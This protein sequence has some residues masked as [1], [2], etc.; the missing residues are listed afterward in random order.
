MAI[1]NRKKNVTTNVI[2]IT[3]SIDKAEILIGLCEGE[4][5]GLENGAKSLYINDTPLQ[6]SAGGDN[7]NDFNVQIYTGSYNDGDVNFMLT[8]STDPTHVGQMLAYNTPVVRSGEKTSI[9]YIS[10][11]LVIQQLMRV[12]DDGTE[13][14]SVNVKIEY[15]AT[16]EGNTWHSLTQDGKPFILSGKVT[17]S[18]ALQFKIKVPKINEPYVLKVT[19]MSEDGDNERNFNSVQFESFQEIYTDKKSFPNTALAHIYMQYSDQLSSVPT[20]SGIYKLLKIRVPSNYDPINHTYNGNWDG[21]FKIA[22][23]DNPAW[24]LYDFVM[25]DRY[26]IN[27]YSSVIIDKWDCYEAGQWCDQMVSDGKGGQEPRYTCNL[28][29]TEATNG[30]EFVSYLAGLFNAFLV[31]PSTGYLRLFID[32]DA[33]AV[34]LFTPENVTEDGFSYSFTSPETRYNDIKVS[35]TNPALNWEADT[36]RI[37]NEEDI[38]K[39]GRVTFDFV[40]VGCIREGEAMRRAYLKLISSLTEKM[41]V[42]FTTNRQAQYLS[43][44]DIILVA[45]PVLGYSLPGRIKSISAD[46]KTVYLR[47]SIYL[48]AGISYKISFNLP[49]GLWETDISPLTLTGSTKTFIVEEEL[50]DNLP[51][52][53]AFTIY[54]SENSGTPKPFRI[55]SITENDGNPDNYTITAIEINRNKWDAADNF[56]FAEMVDYSGLKSMT[57]IPQLLGASFYTGYDRVNLQNEVIITPEFD[58]S[59]PY[60]SGRIIVYSREIGTYAWTQREVVNK[61]TIKGHP[62]GDFE[63]IILPVSTTGIIP[64]FDTAPHFRYTVP[65]VNLYPSNINNLQAERSVNGVTLSWDPVS[66]VDLAGYEIREG[67]DWD[68]STLV[69]TNLAATS[70]YISITDGVTR[71]YMVA[72]KNYL[73]KYSPYPAFIS[74]NV[75]PPEDVPNFYATVSNDRIRFDWTQVEGTDIEYEIRQGANWGTALKVA[76][77]KGNNTTVLLPSIPE[78]T[79][80]I[81][82]KSLA[83][84]YSVNP[85]YTQPDMKLNP[86][87]NIILTEDNG[88]AGF[89]GVTY[90]FE[91]LQFYDEDSGTYRIVP[92]A[93]VMSQEVTRAEHYF[94]VHLQKTTRA[95]N[96]FETEPFA[97]ITRMTWTDLHY[98]W[99]QSEAHTSWIGS[100]ALDSEGEIETVIMKYIGVA[101]KGLF[102]FSYNHTLDD[103]FEEYTPTSSSNISYDSAH[104]VD[105][106]V[107]SENTKV[108]YEN[109]DR[110][111]EVFHVTFKL[112]VDNISSENLNL[113]TLTDGYMKY[114]KIFTCD[115]KLYC[116]GSD[117]KDLIIDY[118][119]NATLDFLTIGIS[120]STTQR[121]LYFYADYANFEAS[122]IIEAEPIG[123]FTKYYINKGIGEYL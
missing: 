112:R 107:L 40:A 109:I 33:D 69:V 116:R 96:W 55:T 123:K 42:T 19:K 104:I 72:A 25:N 2:N 21:T 122:K 5:E 7:F 44:F 81:K 43:N 64:A 86:N 47:D 85:R 62:S 89:P 91:T 38:D 67:E 3:D 105:G 78:I 17:S 35:F 114:L 80:C 41:S 95:R 16:S 71:H 103:I 90:G 77:V 23:S 10:L 70:F 115:G 31:E 20:I 28:L 24:C 113:I 79:Y 4:I 52:L 45:D 53:A 48:E 37:Y 50:P 27:A 29:Q 82:A 117:Y 51:E 34:F 121:S 102:G 97:N 56:E 106:L 30:R 22:W 75:I 108:S 66:D 119:H 26:G 46:R 49:D 15:Q 13:G 111:P 60:Y 74:T 83:G 6:N 88:N 61:N 101:Y 84:L 65:S 11:R 100:H 59:Y 98:R 39:N 76:S 63:F 93:L 32:K 8:G 87:R 58:E 110:L 99:S 12:T 1:W 120:Q 57:N 94:P 18:T 36:R 73:E 118:K 14:N 92:N 54:G 9:D 68:S